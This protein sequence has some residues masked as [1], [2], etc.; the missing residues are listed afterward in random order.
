MPWK[1]G[2]WS[3]LS[4][5]HRQSCQQPTLRSSSLLDRG[6]GELVRCFDWSRAASANLRISSAIDPVRV[7]AFRLTLS[8]SCSTYPRAPLFPILVSKKRFLVAH[9]FWLIERPKISF[10]QNL[11]ALEELFWLSW[12]LYNCTYK[13]SPLTSFALK[14]SFRICANQEFRLS[15]WSRYSA[16]SPDESPAPATA[17]GENS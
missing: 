13:L 17:V 8:A 1:R 12:L 10:T 6:Q 3:S 9:Q 2:V 14:A 5:R 15:V 11:R 7:S 4:L 16:F